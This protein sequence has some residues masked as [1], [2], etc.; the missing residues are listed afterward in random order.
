MAVIAVA[1]TAAVGACLLPENEYAR[2]RS[3]EGTPHEVLR[4]IYERSNFDPTPIDVVFVGHS[5]IGKCVSAPRLSA[6]LAARGLPAHVENFSQPDTG[7][8]INY[9]IVEQVLRTKHPKLLVIGVTEKPSRFGHKA[10]KYIASTADIANPVYVGN[11]SWFADI[12]YLPFRHLKGFASLIAENLGLED[13]R[14]S[15]ATYAG[16]SRETTGSTIAST[17]K[18]LEG[19]IPGNP[20]GLRVGA[21]HFLA[22]NH[23]PVLPDRFADIEFGDD[24]AYVRRIVALAHAHGVRVAFLFVPFYTGPTDVQENRFY[25]G[26]GPVWKADFTANRANW[27]MDY[28]HLTDTGADHVTDWLVD[29]VAGELQSP[30][31]KP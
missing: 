15:P 6:A 10:Y 21:A 13:D 31:P 20:E 12:V 16:S 23:R 26:Y 18:R 17:G 5:R 4:W 1:V 30:A 27:Y 19:H 25:G 9:A 14:F 7:R 24:R 2:W 3:L 28:A 11:V 22:S 29:R 8:N